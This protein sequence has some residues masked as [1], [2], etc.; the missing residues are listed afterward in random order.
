M[1]LAP[2]PAILLWVLPGGVLLH[3]DQ[4]F[5]F[6]FQ[7]ICDYNTVCFLHRHQLS[8]CNPRR[9]S[10]T[11]KR[12]CSI[13]VA[14]LLSQLPLPDHNY[15]G[16]KPLQ[17]YLK[18]SLTIT[19]EE[20]D[21][22]VARAVTSAVE[23]A[24][25]SASELFKTKIEE[26]QQSCEGQR[27]NIHELTKR[28]K[29]LESANNNLEQYSRRSHLRL[30]GLKIEKGKDCKETVSE[31]VSSNL[32]DNEGCSITLTPNAIDAAYPLRS[33]NQDSD[34][35]VVRDAVIKASRQLKGKGVSI[36]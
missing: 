34:Q 3:Y 21:L 32:K 35:R 16:W 27:D 8:I 23:S 18:R 33:H 28:T 14:N 7:C 6:E 12:P 13:I 30:H 15:H 1:H 4:F 20:L 9:Q 26:L 22:L 11:S 25:Q 19:K 36:A 2:T 10:F 29:K 31:F 5:G 24:M 17:K